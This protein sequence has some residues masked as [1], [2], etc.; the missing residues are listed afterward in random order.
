MKTLWITLVGIIGL[1]GTG[2]AVFF[3][4]KKL[5]KDS[6]KV[7]SQEDEIQRKTRVLEDVEIAKNIRESDVNITRD[8]LVDQLREKSKRDK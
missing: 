1:I 3:Q 8:E 6:E 2:I 4:G 7:K 5:G